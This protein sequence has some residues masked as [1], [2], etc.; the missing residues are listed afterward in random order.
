MTPY[1]EAVFGTV[2]IFLKSSRKSRRQVREWDSIEKNSLMLAGIMCRDEFS[3]E[4]D[5]GK[6]LFRICLKMLSE[7]ASMFTC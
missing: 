5:K 6:P 3:V 2:V 7:R 4:M 1:E